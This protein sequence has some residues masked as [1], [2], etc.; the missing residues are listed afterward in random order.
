MAT[1]EAVVYHG[2]GDVRIEAISV[3][4]AGPGELLVR[5]DACA[6]CGTDLKAHASGNPRIK[7]PMVMG[8]EFTGRLAEVGAE[9]SGYQVGQRVVMA[10]SVSCGQCA[11]CRRGLANLCV[12][13]TPMGFGYPGGMAGYTVIPARAVAN[14]HVVIV[15]PELPANVAALAE[16]VSCAVN[17]MG[18]CRLTPGDSLLVIGAGPMG[19]INALVARA[20]GAAKVMLAEVNPARLEQARPFGFD[21]LVN[22]ATEDLAAVVR[23]ETAGLGVDVALVAAPAAAPMEQAMALVRKQGAV[24][25]FASLPAGRSELTIDSRTIH[26]GE[27]HV[28]GSSDSTA[29]HVAKAVALLADPRLMAERL[30]TH[31]LP[32]SRVHEAF[33]LMR[34]GE[35]LRVVLTPS[36]TAA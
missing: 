3:P 18:N 11:Y 26:Y 6:V 7:A 28:V 13:L 22:P 20:M 12:E 23:A 1:T 9:L 8:H 36:P 25:L 24:C 10:T 15:P 4:Q 32:L 19:I 35:C 21:R 14:G 5:I 16:P 34:S 29:A 27:V 2:P 31:V 30:V 33:D 17:A